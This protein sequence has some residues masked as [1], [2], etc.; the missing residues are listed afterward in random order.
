M[1]PLDPPVLVG[2]LS[3]ALSSNS[4]C[5]HLKLASQTLYSWLGTLKL[6]VWKFKTRGM[7][8]YFQ[9]TV[10]N[11]RYHISMDVFLLFTC[12]HPFCHVDTCLLT[13]LAHMIQQVSSRRRRQ[14]ITTSTRL[15]ITSTCVLVWELHGSLDIPVDSPT[16]T[17]G[18][19]VKVLVHLT[20]LLYSTWQ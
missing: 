7:D 14:H 16:F 5:Q 6:G 3:F 9:R 13:C 8:L 19:P 12:A 17:L 1:D 20:T 2:I 4:G 10:H 15:Y 11:F 18:P